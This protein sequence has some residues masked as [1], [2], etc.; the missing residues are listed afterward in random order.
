[1]ETQPLRVLIT[2]AASNLAYS[3][4]PIIGRG[5][6]FGQHQKLALHL[7]DVD[8]SMEKVLLGKSH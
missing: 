6:V 7:Y 2:S 3:L 5:D 1:M 4:I 8:P